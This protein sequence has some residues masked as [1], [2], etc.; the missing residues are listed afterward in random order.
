MIDGDPFLD[1]EAKKTHTHTH[2]LWNCPLNAANELL[3]H[4]PPHCSMNTM[5]CCFL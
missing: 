1:L 4:Q 3:T 2:T 5:G